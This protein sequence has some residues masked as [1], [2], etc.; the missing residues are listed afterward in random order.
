MKHMY[1]MLLG[2]KVT[3]TEQIAVVEIWKMTEV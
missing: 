1:S 3:L 2:V